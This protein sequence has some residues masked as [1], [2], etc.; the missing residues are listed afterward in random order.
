MCQFVKELGR[1]SA[2]E[3]FFERLG[4]PFDPKVVQVKRLHI[5]KRFQEYLN[6]SGAEAGICSRSEDE[7]RALYRT[8]LEQAY[9]D[10]VTGDPL[11]ERVFKVLKDAVPSPAFVPVAGIERFR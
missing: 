9:Q 6:Q 7:T 8:A 1:V 11:T 3:E 4:V 10:F 2:A 5:L